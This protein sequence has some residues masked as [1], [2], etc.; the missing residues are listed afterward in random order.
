[1]KNKDQILLEQAYS[2]VVNE[3]LGFGKKPQDENN[4]GVKFVNLLA[5]GLIAKGFKHQ[6]I[7]GG[8]QFVKDNG[9]GML[10]TISVGGD[11]DRFKETPVSVL[12]K[13][14]E[15]ELYKNWNFVSQQ[16]MYPYRKDLSGADM[17]DRKKAY[18][19]DSEWEEG[20]RKKVGQIYDVVAAFDSA[21]QGKMQAL[22][23]Q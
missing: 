17:D 18:A 22:M 7:S 11:K 10:M 15:Q 19:E 14:G 16:A 6:S 8:F 5:K 1:M 9:H 20:Q 3:F 21:D 4:F 12:I 2:T 13:Y 23:A